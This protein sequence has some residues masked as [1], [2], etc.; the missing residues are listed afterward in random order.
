M[1]RTPLA[2]APVRAVV[3]YWSAVKFH[4]NVLP[5][6]AGGNSAATPLTL[7]SGSSWLNIRAP[8]IRSAYGRRRADERSGFVEPANASARIGAGTGVGTSM[9]TD[10]RL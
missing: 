3:S 9:I 1:N 8:S 6:Y 10:D 2:G 4:S 7:I 5:A